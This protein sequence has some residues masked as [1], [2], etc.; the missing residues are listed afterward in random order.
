MSAVNDTPTINAISAQSTNEDTAL[1]VTVTFGD[2]DGDALTPIAV[3]GNAALVP[4]ANL[5]FSGSGNSRTLTITP[6]P[7]A[8]GSTL[9]TVTVSDPQN[10]AAL[11]SFQLTVFPVNDAP[12]LSGLNQQ[13]GQEDTLFSY[14]GIVVSDVDSPVGNIVLSGSSANQALVSDANIS[15]GGSGGTR[16]IS[17]MPQPNQSGLAVISI[18][19]S[20]GQANSPQGIFNVEFNPVNDA[21]TISGIGNQSTNE[22][23]SIGPIGF[24]VADI[25]NVAGSL[26]L[27]WSSSNT[28]LVPASNITPGGSGANRNISINPAPNQF[29]TA[30]ISVTV[31]DGAA[32]ATTSFVLTVNPVNDAPTISS[33]PNQFVQES[34]SS[35]QI[36]FTINDFETAGT[37]LIITAVSSDQ[38]IVQNAGLVLGGSG[39]N[40]TLTIT[41]VQFQNGNVNVTLT[42]RDL[43]GLTASTQ[44]LVSVDEV[45]DA[46]TISPIGDASITEDGVMGPIAFQVNDVETPPAQL[47][48]TVSSSNLILVPLSAIKVL[49]SG[50]NRTITITPLAD[51]AGFSDI[52][53]TLVD[54]AI[55]VNETFRLSVDAVNDRPRITPI[56]PLTMNEDTVTTTTFYGE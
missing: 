44:F 27:V 39:N 13:N 18:I 37:N 15:F 42:V 21:P 38:N 10:A 24:T 47:S 2:V 3:A 40:R 43:E 46:P 23:T 30:T 19:A 20:D 32:S 51:N 25:D 29:G 11:T 31:Q 5:A 53:L 45:N 6:A 4:N 1:N 17:M 14:N 49:G 52:T 55:T 12:T 28:T 41:P 48:P 7:N 33:V 35:G 54:G 22:D 36:A 56:S 9:I 50:I 16:S 34:G 26:T 8:N